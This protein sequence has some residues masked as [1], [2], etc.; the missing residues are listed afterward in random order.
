MSEDCYIKFVDVPEGARIYTRELYAKG[1]T[2]MPAPTQGN[3]QPSL[4]WPRN[5]TCW[6][7]VERDGYI[8]Q[9]YQIFLQSSYTLQLDDWF[10]T[11]N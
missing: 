10:R 9:Y 5:T 6:L 2:E 8:D 11:G 1:F 3:L 4:V 7:K